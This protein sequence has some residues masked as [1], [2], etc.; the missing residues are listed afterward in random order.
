MGHPV[1]KYTHRTE[2]LRDDDDAAHTN[3]TISPDFHTTYIYMVHVIGLRVH[4]SPGR[5]CVHLESHLLLLL[6]LLIPKWSKAVRLTGTHSSHARRRRPVVRDS[7][8]VDNASPPQFGQFAERRVG[9]I[10]IGRLNTGRPSHTYIH[11]QTYSHRGFRTT[12]I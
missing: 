4:G 1:Y 10:L 11:I 3:K 9:I 2:H 8:I 12:A 6:L 7:Y 5:W